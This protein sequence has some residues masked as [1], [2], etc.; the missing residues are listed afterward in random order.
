MISKDLQDT[1]EFP[2]PASPAKVQAPRVVSF[3]VQ[4]D[5][6]ALSHQGNVRANNEDH[7]LVT[8]FGRTL[9]ALMTN[10]PEGLIPEQFNDVGYG[11]LVADGIGG[12][13]GGEM[14]SRTAISTLVNLVL[15]TPDWIMLTGEEEI[16]RV[17]ERMEHRY[18]RINATLAEQAR[19][20]PALSGMGTTMTLACIFGPYLLLTHIGDSRAYLLRD[21]ELHQ[22]TQDHTLAQALV[23]VGLIPQKEVAT[24]RLRHILSHALGGSGGQVKVEV[25]H[26]SLADRDQVL[27]CTDGLTEMVADAAITAVLQSAGSAREAGQALVDL[28]LKNGGKDNVTVAL[29]RYRLAP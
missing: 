25:Q 29:A 27:L 20:D 24:H 3:N 14:A 6:A 1:Q 10:L 23:G 13:S 18:W 17:M 26:L 16:D 7:Y 11:L 21:G 8:R 28:A 5:L 19:L 12:S 15:D 4:V 2:A 9:E 22:L